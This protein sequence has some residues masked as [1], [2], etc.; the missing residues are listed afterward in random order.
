MGTAT[1]VFA[2]VL[3]LFTALS[4]CLETTSFVKP[5]TAEGMYATYCN[6]CHGDPAVGTPDFAPP[7]AG[8]EAKEIVDHV[9]GR[10]PGLMNELLPHGLPPDS[11][12]EEDALRIAEYLEALE[13]PAG[14]E[15]ARSDMDH[16]DKPTAWLR[17]RGVLPPMEIKDHDAHGSQGGEEGPGGPGTGGHGDRGTGMTPGHK[18]GEH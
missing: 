13:R 18:E 15:K 6:T 5:G 2:A 4:G 8:I 9:M 16:A 12:T 1:P 11:I 3:L 14:W 17:F 10:T 7:L